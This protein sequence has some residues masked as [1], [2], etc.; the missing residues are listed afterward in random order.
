MCDVT[1]QE[2]DYLDAHVEMYI[3]HARVHTTFAPMASPGFTRLTP[4]PRP[5]PPR[6]PSPA[7]TAARC[8]SPRATA[9]SLARRRAPRSQPSAQ[10]PT[11]WPR[12]GTRHRE[13]AGRGRGRTLVEALYRSTFTDFVA[14]SAALVFSN[15]CVGVA[16]T[17]P[18]QRPAEAL[19]DSRSSR[20]AAAPRAAA[21]RDPARAGHRQQ[22][23]SC[24]RQ[25]HHP[26]P[27][28]ITQRQHQQC[29]GAPWAA[30]NDDAP[31]HPRSS[32]APPQTRRSALHSRRC[33]AITQPNTYK[34]EHMLKHTH[35]ETKKRDIHTYTY[36]HIT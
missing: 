29:S 19:H 10:T 25:S 18:R 36:T 32:S 3:A 34:H 11:Q 1:L 16:L 26:A 8:I 15:S 27:S 28:T 23:V 13:R 17:S 2:K 24:A 9:G 4:S 5:L 7:W 6:A 30:H 12:R 21:Q 14:S 20:S 31:G 33:G 35:T 22:D